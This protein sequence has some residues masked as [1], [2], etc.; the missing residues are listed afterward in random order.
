MIQRL[1]C[2]LDEGNHLHQ[3]TT[4]ENQAQF[5]ALMAAL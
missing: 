5:T 4:L 1:V 2:W 3:L